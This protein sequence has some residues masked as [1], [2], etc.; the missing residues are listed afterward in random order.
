MVRGQLGGY[1]GRVITNGD[2]SFVDVR[3]HEAE[4]RVAYTLEVATD[5][6]EHGTHLGYPGAP[7]I[8]R[9]LLHMAL[10]L[11]DADRA[12]QRA[13]YKPGSS[14]PLE[15]AGNVAAGWGDTLTTIPFTDLCGTCAIRRG[16]GIDVVDYQHGGYFVGG[17]IGLGNSVGLGYALGLKGAGVKASGLQFSHWIPEKVL[18]R[19]PLVMRSWA[20]KKFGRSLWNG[21]YVTPLRHYKHDPAFFGGGARGPGMLRGLAAAGVPRFPWLIRHLDRFPRVLYGVIGGTVWGTAGDTPER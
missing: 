5:L 8:D 18:K 15:I 21:N 6:F 13:L 20:V 16:L 14:I 11:M 2:T 4:I 9:R 1:D 7:E 17:L 10:N 3:R 12:V 19:V